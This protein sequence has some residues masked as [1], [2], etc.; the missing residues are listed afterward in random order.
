MFMFANIKQLA[1]VGATVAGVGWVTVLNPATAHTQPLPIPPG[2]N[3]TCP[4]IAGVNYAQDPDDSNAY[5]TCVDG[6]QQSRTQCPP[7]QKLAMGT[8][9]KCVTRHHM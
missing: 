1:V 8:P 3:F 9:P 7:S 2:N 6:Q 4:D 5:Y